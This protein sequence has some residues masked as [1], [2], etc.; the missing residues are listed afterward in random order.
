[1]PLRG[2]RKGGSLGGGEHAQQQQRSQHVGRQQA[3]RHQTVRACH[4]ILDVDQ[5]QDGQTDE[6]QQGRHQV[7]ARDLL[8]QTPQNAEADQ[9]NAAR[10]GDDE[11]STGEKEAA[12]GGV[13]TARA[14]LRNEANDGRRE[15]EIGEI[16]QHQDPGPNLHVNGVVVGPPSSAPARSG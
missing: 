9:G 7:G 1:M 13:L 2:D 10:D 12:Q 14:M 5:G 15:P 4:P 3:E 8:A 6:T 16:A 11:Q